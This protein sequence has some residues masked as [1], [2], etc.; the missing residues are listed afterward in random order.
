MPEAPHNEDGKNWLKMRYDQ[1][2]IEKNCCFLMGYMNGDIHRFHW[3]IVNLD[4][5]SCFSFTNG[6]ST[7]WGID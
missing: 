2:K 4:L 3:N 6:K 1:P 7:T 5:L